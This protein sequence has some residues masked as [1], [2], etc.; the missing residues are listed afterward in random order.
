MKKYSKHLLKIVGI[1]V[2]LCFAALFLCD[3][4]IRLYAKDRIYDDI[5]LLPTNKVGLLLGTSKYRKDGSNNPFFNNRIDAAAQLYKARKI[6]III[7]SGDKSRGYDEPQ[8]MRQELIKKGVPDSVIY[9]DNF[10]FRTID[11]VLRCEKV[12]DQDSFTI[13]SQK[14]HNER[15]IFIA[16]QYGINAIAFNAKPVELSDSLKT[17]SRELFAR[18][19]AVLDVFLP[20]LNFE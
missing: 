12:F 19:R 5:D 17:R 14:F 10:G 3:I 8:K 4:F 18:V 15:A 20:D 2:L 11:S 1:V 13:I 9:A 16:K 6:E 7:A